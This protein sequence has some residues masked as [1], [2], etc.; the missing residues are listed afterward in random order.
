M[1]RAAALIHE[2]QIVRLHRRLLD[3]IRGAKAML[4][5]AAGAKIPE[6]RLHHRPQVARRVVAKLD[7]ATRIAIEHEN[8]STPDLG[9]RH[10]HIVIPI[11]GSE[12]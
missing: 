11:L 12:N 2:L 4:E 1:I 3:R 7:Y 6:L 10:C 5:T 9:G 8:H